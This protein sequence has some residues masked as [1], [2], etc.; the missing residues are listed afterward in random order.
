MTS[1]TQSFSFGKAAFSRGLRVFCKWLFLGACACASAFLL[2]QSF[3]YPSHSFLAWL[4]LAP[5]VW[6][7]RYTRSFWGGF[8]YGGITSFLFHANALYWIYYTCV[9]GGGMSIGLAACAWLGLA[10]LLSLQF[11]LWGGCCHF[12]L[13]LR[14][15]FPLVAAGGWVALE[16]LHQT[17]AFYG[18]GFPWFML[19]YTQWNAPEFLQLASYTGVYGISFVIV[20]TGTTVG[21]AF[22]E[23]HFKKSI[24]QLLWAA[25]IFLAVYGLGYYK[26]KESDKSSTHLVH[27]KAAL[28][29]PNID[30]YKKWSPEFE[31]EIKQTL[32]GMGNS[33]VGKNMHLALWPESAL[34]SGL[35]EEPYYTL[36]KDIAKDSG[37]YQLLGSNIDQNGFSYV[38]AYLVPSGDTNLQTYK[39]IKLVPFGEYIPFE[40]WIR[41]Y[42]KNIEVLGE[43]GSFSFGSTD[44]SLID[45]HGVLLGTTICY[46]A[47][48]PQLWH[49]QA[50]QGAQLFVNL[51]NDAWFFNTAAPY[52]HLAANVLRAVESG[53]PVLRAANTGFS[54]YIDAY[55]RIVEKTPLFEQTVLYV[56]VPLLT[57]NS[58]VY[59]E[60]GDWFAWLCAIC[61]FT[62]LIST[63]VFIYE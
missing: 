56:D 40:K 33:L 38:G 3:P 54:A 23:P 5:F 18:L 28:L 43:L 4:A 36:M 62:W 27:V 51:T 6:G 10:L 52:Q 20:L 13:R 55:G 22:I 21:W 2:Y 1:N 34:P 26:L 32:A 39:K 58:N 60:W 57:V 44:Q 59:T 50:K 53:K 17:I 37:A 45:M 48:F 16:W 7:L 46:E 35:M 8:L 12:L 9:N 19:G 29:Q 14:G 25:C 61:F 30:Q 15:L 11:A 24:G 47:I 31:E 41:Y 63:I 42:F 49:M